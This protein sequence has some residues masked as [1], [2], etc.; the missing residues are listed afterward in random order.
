MKEIKLRGYDKY[1]KRMI[2]N[3]DVL[4]VDASELKAGMYDS[5]EDYYE[6][7]LMHWVGEKDKHNINIFENDFVKFTIIYDGVLITHYG[8]VKFECGAFIIESN[9]ITDHY[10]TFLEI[11]RDG[12]DI[13]VV[14]NIFDNYLHQINNKKYEV[15]KL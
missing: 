7:E 3:Y 8:H 6:L 1:K 12:W 2:Y 14:G 11:T 15:R 9:T 5:N 10:L 13:E 4:T